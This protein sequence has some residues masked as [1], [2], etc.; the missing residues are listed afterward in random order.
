MYIRPIIRPIVALFVV[1]SI[2]R[3]QSTYTFTPIA[4][5]ATTGFSG[6]SDVVLNERG[7]LA[8]VGLSGD[9]QTGGAAVYVGRGGELTVI[10]TNFRYR[11][12]HLGARALNDAGQVA[13]AVSRVRS[14][15]YDS[16]VFVGSGGALT[17][18]AREA[19][20]ACDAAGNCSAIGYFGP[21]ITPVGRAVFFR[22]IDTSDDQFRAFL[23]GTGGRL[24]SV[25]DSQTGSLVYLDASP[26]VNSAN[27]VAFY[28]LDVDAGNDGIFLADRNGVRRMYDARGEQ[29]H[30]ILVPTD[31][32]LNRGG[33]IAFVK[34][35]DFGRPICVLRGDGPEL[36]TIAER[37][38]PFIGFGDRVSLNDLGEV[39]FTGFT[40]ATATGLTIYVGDGARVERV[41]GAGDTLFGRVVETWGSQISVNDRGQVAFRVVFT[42]DSEAVVRADC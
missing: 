22:E 19:G 24:R 35:G 42:D 10:A 23:T 7:D 31:P 6:F 39:A 16:R 15:D 21:S 34:R 32:S 40:D 28:A 27:Q 26:D 13:F 33:S 8:F 25:A 18:I 17:L 30:P 38:D 2:A 5:T 1:S 29:E 3:A 11:D 4:D 37:V 20:I 12:V 9:F 14:R 41:I 36:T